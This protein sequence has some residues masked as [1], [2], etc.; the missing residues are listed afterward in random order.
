LWGKKSSFTVEGTTKGEKRRRR[1][2]S[3]S[4]LSVDVLSPGDVQLV[5]EQLIHQSSAD[6]S[7]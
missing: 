1:V 4:L 3:M 7:M 6:V 5:C 2:F